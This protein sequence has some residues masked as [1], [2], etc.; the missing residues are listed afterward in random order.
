MDTMIVYLDDAAYARHLLA[1]MLDTGTATRWVLVACAPRMS[2]HISKWLSHSA[3]E[4][5]RKKWSDSLFAQI[6]PCLTAPGGASVQTVECILAQGAL[7]QLTARLRSRLGAA[8]HV[9]DARRPKFGQELP[10]VTFD[11][12]RE[13]AGWQ[14][15]TAVGGLSA[16]L[17]LASE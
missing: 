13:K 1:P 4:M 9:V 15:S 8:A 6:T 7:P 2:R 5:W 11:Q 10:P 17:V 12:P 3:R 14:V 16:V